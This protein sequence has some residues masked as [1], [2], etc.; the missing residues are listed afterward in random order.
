MVQNTVCPGT[1]SAEFLVMVQNVPSVLMDMSQGRN[2][3]ILS[4]KATLT[5]GTK[6][7]IGAVRQPHKQSK[8][9]VTHMSMNAGK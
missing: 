1:D 8:Q 6:E 5:D 2:G 3:M 4:A 7:T 9:G